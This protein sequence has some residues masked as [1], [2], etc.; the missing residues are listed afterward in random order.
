MT[1]ISWALALLCSA[2][3]LVFAYSFWIAAQK[4]PDMGGP[5]P[6]TD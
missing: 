1:R 2:I 5:T 6:I 3:L 4:S